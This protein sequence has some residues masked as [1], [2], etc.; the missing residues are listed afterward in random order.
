MT[1]VVDPA[2]SICQPVHP[3]DP[4]ARPAVNPHV[5]VPA[6]IVLSGGC[7]R[8]S[9]NSVCC[10]ADLPPTTSVPATGPLAHLP[11]K[12]TGGLDQRPQEI[13]EVVVPYCAWHFEH[14]DAGH[15]FHLVAYSCGQDGF[16]LQ[17]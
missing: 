2:V 15:L 17:P 12:T 4:I 3:E 5:T 14:L 8:S 1:S 10:C 11:T 13:T 9:T 16:L 7:R 6:W